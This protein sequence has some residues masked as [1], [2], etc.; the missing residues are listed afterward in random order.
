MRRMLR[1]AMGIWALGT[2]LHL[3]TAVSAMRENREFDKAHMVVRTIL[4]VAT[5]AV[6]PYVWMR[7]VP[8]EVG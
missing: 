7:P 4:C 2:I 3:P 5:A 1:C 6:W 8:R